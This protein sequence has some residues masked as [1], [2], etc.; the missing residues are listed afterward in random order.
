MERLLARGELQLSEVDLETSDRLHPHSPA[1]RARNKRRRREKRESGKVIGRAWLTLQ[2]EQ[3]ILHCIIN[4]ADPS[5]L[6]SLRLVSRFLKTAADERLAQHIV[7]SD[8]GRR[9]SALYPV[10]SDQWAFSRIVRVLDVSCD[11]PQ[12]VRLHRLRHPKRPTRRRPYPNLEMARFIKQLGAGRQPDGQ[13]RA[14]EHLGIWPPRNKQNVPTAIVAYVPS[15]AEC[16]ADFDVPR[17][18][19]EII[20]A[21]SLDRV[22]DGKCNFRAWRDPMREGRAPELQLL[23]LPGMEGSVKTSPG[24]IRRALDGWLD[25]ACASLKDGSISHVLF[26]GLEQYFE[27]ERDA[28]S[29][30]LPELWRAGCAPGYT[31]LSCW[32]HGRVARHAEKGID[33]I[34]LVEEAYIEQRAWKQR[35]LQESDRLRKGKP[36]GLGEERAKVDKE[37]AEL[38]E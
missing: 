1:A 6:V 32:G 17:G 2:N 22:V 19:K 15:N 23:F 37:E 20:C 33:I 27:Y 3:R 18:C 13:R 10:W 31:S 21:T 38:S 24:D 30:R 29:H 35:K 26:V 16:S 8:G 36:G 5:T 7:M 9:S 34:H 12:S 25:S 4:H 14:G 28:F 11:E